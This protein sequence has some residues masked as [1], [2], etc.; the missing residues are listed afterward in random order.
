MKADATS[1]AMFSLQAAEQTDDDVRQLVRSL[2]E[3]DTHVHA[4]DSSDSHVRVTYKTKGKVLR[5]LKV[6]IPVTGEAYVSGDT[7]VTYPWYASMAGVRTDIKTRFD[8]RIASQIESES[9]SPS[10]RI[11]L[12]S[13]MHA[14]FTEEFAS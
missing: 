5:F 8:A 11:Q 7:A 1:N 10:N 14:F 6:T 12:I 9:L 4:I 3:N 13:E 2:L